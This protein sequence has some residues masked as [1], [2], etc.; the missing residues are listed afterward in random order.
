MAISRLQPLESTLVR[1]SHTAFQLVS[2]ERPASDARR[3]RMAPPTLVMKPYEFSLS[4]N[5]SST[6]PKASV[7]KPLNSRLRSFVISVSGRSS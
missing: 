1:T 3:S 6:M 4:L 7:E 2:F 5:V